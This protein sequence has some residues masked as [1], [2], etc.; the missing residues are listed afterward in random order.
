MPFDQIARFF[1]PE[2]LT[3]LN[4]A[5]EQAWQELKESGDVTDATSARR[6]LRTTIMALASVGERD[7]VKLKRFALH[8][9]RH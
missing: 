1:R 3:L 6:Q 9:A 7:A 5:L 2:T 8:A 4:G